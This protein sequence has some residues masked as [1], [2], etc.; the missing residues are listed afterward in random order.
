MNWGMLKIRC[1]YCRG[2]GRYCWENGVRV[3]GTGIRCQ[4]CAGRGWKS[5]RPGSGPVWVSPCVKSAIPKPRKPLQEEPPP[6]PSIYA[7]RR[8][9]S[10]VEVHIEHDIHSGR[11]VIRYAPWNGVE[12]GAGQYEPPL[13]GWFEE[14]LRVLEQYK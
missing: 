14:F 5:G 10:G 8:I 1:K 9:I 3:F 12:Y 6:P 11:G 7:V 4:L 2:T 13:Y